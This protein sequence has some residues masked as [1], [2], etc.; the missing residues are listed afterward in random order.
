MDLQELKSDA[1]GFAV[2]LQDLLVDGDVDPAGLEK[3][4]ERVRHHLKKENYDVVL[5][6]AGIRVPPS[7]F[8]LFEH[9][10]NITFLD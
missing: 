8:P 1:S 3:S 5:I 2:L 9:L 7:N 10:V 4:G 6:G